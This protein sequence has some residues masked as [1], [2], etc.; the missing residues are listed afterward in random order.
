MVQQRKKKKQADTNVYRKVNYWKRRSHGGKVR[1]KEI[2][3]KSFFCVVQVCIRRC[4]RNNFDDAIF[5][6]AWSL[7]SH[8]FRIV[9]PRVSVEPVDIA[10]VSN[11][12]FVFDFFLE[13]SFNNKKKKKKVSNFLSPVF[14]GCNEAPLERSVVQEVRQGGGGAVGSGL[15]RWCRFNLGRHRGLYC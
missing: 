3:M 14:C 7:A 13:E 12:S 9:N 2:F 15:F 11:V 10:V 1:T 6:F 4:N 8:V 5:L